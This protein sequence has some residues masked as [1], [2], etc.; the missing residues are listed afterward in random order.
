M[1]CSAGLS[2]AIGAVLALLL[3]ITAPTPAVAQLSPPARVAT[4]GVKVVG[5]LATLTAAAI[6]AGPGTPIYNANVD[7]LRVGLKV[8]FVTGRPIVIEAIK[9]TARAVPAASLSATQLAMDLG[10]QGVN[11]QLSSEYT[12]Q[13]DSLPGEVFYHYSQSRYAASFANGLKPSTYV[14]TVSNLTGSEAHEQLSLPHADPPDAVYT[15]TL[16]AGTPIA[17]NPLHPTAKPKFGRLGGAPE[18]IVLQQTP[19]GSVSAPQPIPP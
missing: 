18:F 11:L 4:H 12:A 1:R 8:H 16:P 17:W 7:L 2:R 14:T 6:I 5:L 9:A 13:R 15:V 19:P 10:L 3:T